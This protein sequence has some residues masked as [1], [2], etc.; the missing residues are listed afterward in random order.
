MNSDQRKSGVTGVTWNKQLKSWVAVWRNK[1]GETCSRSFNVAKLG[2][3]ASLAQAIK[4]RQSMTN[5]RPQSSTVST[6]VDTPSTVDSPLDDAPLTEI[7]SSP[8]TVI[9]V[10][11]PSLQE[12]NIINNTFNITDCTL[13]FFEICNPSS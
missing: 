6:A 8:V 9:P 12:T 11:Q 13:S 3:E 1:N 5:S 10:M 2:E 4:L 7:Q